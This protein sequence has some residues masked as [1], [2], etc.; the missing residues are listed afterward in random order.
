MPGNILRER[1]VGVWS[2]Q[3]LAELGRSGFTTDPLRE[4]TV[5]LTKYAGREVQLRLRHS[6]GPVEYIGAVPLGWWVDDIAI[7]N[8][9]WSTLATVAGT[10]Y[11][12]RLGAGTHSM[13]VMT[14]YAIRGKRVTGDASVPVTAKVAAGVAAPKPAPAPK[15]TG[16]PCDRGRIAAGLVVGGTRRG[17]DARRLATAQTTV[18]CPACVT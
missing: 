13:R 7:A 8:E 11:K 2:D 5:D 16:P 6:S 12:A 15:P 17:G 3:V 10:S 14:A 18:A 1:L 9:R 4:R